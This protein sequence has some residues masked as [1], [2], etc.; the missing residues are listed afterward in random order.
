MNSTL[1]R[2]SA[3]GLGFK[4]MIPIA[5]VLLTAVLAILFVVHAQNEQIYQER[6]DRTMR[7]TEVVH[8]ITESELI[9]NRRDLLPEIYR[10]LQ[11]KGAVDRIRLIG[12]EGQVV[13]ST[14]LEEI[15]KI[16]DR[17]SAGCVE[18]HKSGKNPS[19][20]DQPYA[21]FE[22]FR[23]DGRVL[24]VAY[25]LLN[26]LTCQGKGCHSPDDTKALGVVE[27]ELSF[28]EMDEK[29][30]ALNLQIFLV[31][32][33][34]LL[35]VIG[36]I[37]A[38]THVAVNR[39]IKRLLRGTK[40]VRAGDMDT[41]IPVA[42]DDEIGHLAAS[43]NEMVSELKEAKNTGQMRSRALEKKIE[44]LKN[45]QMQLVRSE[46]LASLGKLSAGVAHEINNPLATV[47]TYCYLLKRKAT[48]TVSDM[49]KIEIMISEITRCSQI[50]KGLLDFA[51]ED[52]PVKKSV[53]LDEVLD[54]TLGLISNQ[55][56][57]H[58]ISIHRSKAEDLP[59]IMADG[60][61]IQQVIMNIAINAAEAM[62]EG[63]E[64]FI[65][66]CVKGGFVQ[67]EFRDTGHGIKPENITRI[68]D[69]FFSSKKGGRGT[70]LGL[71]VSYSIVERHG[72]EIEVTSTPDEGTSF[73]MRL[74]V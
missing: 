1:Q 71:A 32:G 8:S 46:K 52:E 9:L 62:R 4:L 44:E 19:V 30:A 12:L 28:R 17:D 16:V 25:P 33:A 24:G 56:I 74:P 22:R 68:F 11:H 14:D 3:I 66:A 36:I 55:S 35:G 60:S 31:A 67:M 53:D 57:F 65:D 27:V 26:Q 20:L 34:V 40:R 41:C 10:T 59:R 54:R 42:S 51:R 6:Q 5:F 43:F 29:L 15:G 13:I 7:F 47:L 18:C 69:P 70:G 37:W 21:K 38:F 50:V 61:Q 23:P 39:P 48:G 72:G 58:N 2:L 64:L 45:T 49:E 63:G 73:F